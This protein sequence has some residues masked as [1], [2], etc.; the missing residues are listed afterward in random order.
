MLRLESLLLPLLLLPLPLMLML[1]LLLLLP[2]T[3]P[4]RTVVAR[5]WFGGREEDGR[6]ERKGEQRDE[7]KIN[8]VT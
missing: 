6:N 8:I 4:C 3:P 5:L 7:L 2:P 1:P